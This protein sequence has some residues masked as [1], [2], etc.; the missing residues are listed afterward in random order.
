MAALSHYTMGTPAS[1]CPCI[2]HGDWKA[3]LE[4]YK[5]RIFNAGKIIRAD[6]G[7]CIIQILRRAS[8]MHAAWRSGGVR[9]CCL[10]M[11]QYAYTRPLVVL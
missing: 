5:Q 6:M 9:D 7:K 11:L 1:V 8:Q 2:H 4:R 3:S 10:A